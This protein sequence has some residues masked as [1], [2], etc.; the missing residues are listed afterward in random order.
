MLL[1]SCC[2]FRELKREKIEL[3]LYNVRTNMP[4]QDVYVGSLFKIGDHNFEDKTDKNGK[5]TLRRKWDYNTP[6]DRM[7]YF[8][9]PLIFKKEGIVLTSIDTTFKEI[10][11]FPLFFSNIKNGDTLFLNVRSTDIKF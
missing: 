4:L 1:S 10:N 7:P 5:F 6:C 9:P 8:T 3:H 2:P 11:K